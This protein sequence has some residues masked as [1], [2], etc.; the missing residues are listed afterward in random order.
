[1]NDSNL[2]PIPQPGETGPQVCE[3]VRLYLAVMDDL[4]PQQIALLSE[5]VNT[6]PDC[7]ATL[8]QLQQATQLVASGLAH[9]T[10]SPHVD[11]AI[12][13][14]L[15][16]P[17]G[18]DLSRPAP[19]YRLA[20]PSWLVG[21]LATAAVLVVALLAAMFMNGISPVNTGLHAFSLPQNLSWS[22]Y[23]LYHS[24][25]SIGNNGRRYYVYTYDNLGQKMMHVETV[26][27][28]LDV[29][30]V[31]DEKS[32]EVLGMDM[33]NH[34]AQWGAD[35]WMVDDSAFDLAQLRHDLATNSAIYLDKDTF[36]GQAV[37]RIRLKNGLMLLLNMQYQP[38]NV[39]QGAVGPGTGEPMYESLEL[40]SS[41]QVSD[42]MW[43]M[44]VP[45]NFHLGTLPPKP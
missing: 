23:V 29:V 30:S 21:S 20:R 31:E 38:V 44:T 10:P 32:G 8:R 42:D 5:H 7:A 36:K 12:M 3:T 9:T 28:S 45:A 25:T 11:R 33:K 27:G 40:M 4:T 26:A 34:V 19:I 15:A 35:A 17:V 24:E 14:V 37:Y 22:S 1:M 2:P 41:S 39:L 16:S 6:C 43:N 18:A 13:A